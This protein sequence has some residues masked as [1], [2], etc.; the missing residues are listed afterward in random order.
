[1]KYPRR[2]PHPDRGC[3]VS[4][5]CKIKPQQPACF[6]E[7]EAL[8]F[9]PSLLMLLSLVYKDGFVNQT[10]TRPPSATCN[11]PLI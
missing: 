1:M 3:V 7:P 2:P 5:Q 8:N 9:S 6:P 10:R 11:Q 4:A